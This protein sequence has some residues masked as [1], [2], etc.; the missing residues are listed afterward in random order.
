MSQLDTR[1]LGS[2]GPAITTVGFGAWAVGGDWLFGWGEQD[3]RDSVA[4]IHHALDLGINWID[5]AAVYG[6]G[7]SEEVVRRAL[8]G[9]TD[10]PLVFTKCG[11]VWD[12]TAE[13]PRPKE[14]LQPAEI[15]RECEDSLRR[16]EIEQIDLYQFHWPDETGTPIEESWT[17]MA[18]L[19]AE[20]KVRW[21]G[22]SN[23][24]AE[25]LS[26][27]E[28]IMHVD[29]LQPP[30]NAVQRGFAGET[31]RWCRDHG[32]GVIVY[33][34]MMS[35]LLTGSFSAERLTSLPET[36]WRHGY[37]EFQDPKLSRNLALQ[38][39]MRPVAERHGVSVAAV[40]VAWTLAWD[41]VTGAIVGARNAEQ[42]DGWAA[43]GSLSFSPDELDEL[44]AAIVA[45]GA[46]EGP[47]HPLREE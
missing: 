7:H 42:V 37:A 33:S 9:M 13:R 12:T 30:F 20:G 25:L 21:A 1:R 39:A 34:P 36:D 18:E 29:S 24:D 45:S 2:Q 17:V 43:S 31:L 27:C 38:A 23:F 28:A 19:V 14:N 44:S 6:L 26:R 3:D 47:S 8:H 32:T 40:A 41:G 4:A 35:G 5:T 11:L 46:G 15:R 16:L 22:V 10:R